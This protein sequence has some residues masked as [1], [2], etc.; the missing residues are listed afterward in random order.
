MAFARK[1]QARSDAVR[2]E[3]VAEAPQPYWNVIGGQAI[4]TGGSRCSAGFNARNSAGTRFVVTAGHCT[5]LGSTWTGLGGTLGTR[6]GM[7]FPGNDYAIISVTSSAAVS[8]PLVDRYSGASDVRVTGAADHERDR[9]HRRERAARGRTAKEF[10]GADHP[11]GARVCIINT[12]APPGH[13]VPL[14]THP[15]E[16][17]Q[18]PAGEAVFFDW[19]SE[20]VVRAGEVAVVPGGAA[21]LPGDRRDELR[22]AGH[23]RQPDVP[24]G[25]AVGRAGGARARIGL[26]PRFGTARREP[27]LLRKGGRGAAAPELIQRADELAALRDVAAAAGAGAGRVVLVEIGT[28]WDRQDI[29]AASGPGDRRRARPPR[30]GSARSRAGTDVRLRGGPA[31]ARPPRRHGRPRLAGGIGR[32]GGAC[33]RPDR[34]GGGGR[35]RR[36][37]AAGAARVVLACGRPRRRDAAGASRRRRALGRRRVAAL[38]GLSR[39]PDGGLAAAAAAGQRDRRSQPPAWPCWPGSRRIPTRSCYGRRCSP[40]TRSAGLSIPDF[41]AAPDV[42]FVSAVERATGGNP[43]L[44]VELVAALEREGLG[45]TAAGS[46]RVAGLGPREIVQ[47]LLRRVAG[48]SAGA[49]ELADAVAVLLGY[50]STSPTRRRWRAWRPARSRWPP[51]RSS[52]PAS[53]RLAASCGSPIRSSARRST[54]RSRPR[55]EPSCTHAPR[56]CSPTVARRRRRS[57]H[58]CSPARRAPT[59]ASPTR[60]APPRARRPIAVHP[61]RRSPICGGRWPSRR[62]AIGWASCSRSWGSPLRPPATPPPPSTSPRRWGT[63]TTPGGRRRCR[64][65]WAGSRSWRERSTAPRPC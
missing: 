9:V 65:S 42:A 55:R 61:T 26:P 10:V 48:L 25:L 56:G 57:R 52:A 43:L 14:D 8:T 60:C 59:R 44:V 4:F 24:D 33:V 7:S 35:I 29:A 13:E 58:T 53:W 40:P 39:R 1:W 37:G 30:A 27:E 18:S 3:H 20:R 49:N 6:A 50:W 38:P 51:T 63:W 46:E 45:P 34:S 15:Y 31:A 19:K 2:I 32:G 64:S 22:R 62:R 11:G 41:E 28:G 5:I 21:R 17:V 54:R 23:P 16:E 12:D 47:R 36:P